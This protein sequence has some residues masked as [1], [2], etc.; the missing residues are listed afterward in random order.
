[1]A[2]KNKKERLKLIRKASI[3]VVIPMIMV[4]CPIIGYLLGDLLDGFIHT[5]PLFTIIFLL[6]GIGAGIRETYEII[7]RIS[8]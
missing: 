3:A 2:D 5:T 8:R 4:T 1:M 7:K 6:A